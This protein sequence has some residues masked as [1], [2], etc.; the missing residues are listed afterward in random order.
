MRP[1]HSCKSCGFISTAGDAF[2]RLLGVKVCVGCAEQY[3]SDPDVTR[4]IDL[5]AQPKGGTP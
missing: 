4:W 2:T 1:L 3:G 5:A